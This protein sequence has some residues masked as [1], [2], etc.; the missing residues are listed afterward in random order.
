[1]PFLRSIDRRR[2]DRSRGQSLVEFALVLPIML[3]LLLAALD[4]GRVYLGWVNLQSM[5]RIAANIAANNP[6][7]WTGAGDAAVKAKYQ[8]QIRNDA[9]AT[10]CQ[11]PLVSGVRTAPEPVFAGTSLGSTVTVGMTCTFDVITPIV[12]AIV[13]K[14]V[15]VSSQAS[16]P[17]KSG[18]TA[19]G[20][21]GGGN[22]SAP[23]AAFTGNATQAPNAITG[24]A[25]FTVVFRDTSG[26][27]PTSWA[28]NFADGATS[29][30]QD[31]LGHTFEN[32]GTYVVTM[33]ATN[34][35][36]YSTQSMG[37]T[38]LASSDVSFTATPM[39]GDRPLKVDF[40][41]TST[42][43]GTA[44]TWNFG[45]GQGTATGQSATKTYNSAGT[46]TVTLT[47]T[48][49]T[50]TKSTTRTITVAPGLCTVPSL[51]GIRVNDA[52][53]EWNKANFTG[54]VTSGPGAP[55]GNYFITAQDIVALSPVPCDSNVMVN[56][57]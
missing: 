15:A 10:N 37:V 9:T 16:F 38:V 11:L 25:P 57:P 6:N 13:G 47:V 33:T 41:D 12:S 4:F 56:R 26:G 45:A 14:S 54:T 36:G 48:Y 5:T 49:P 43:G 39:T 28:W 40:T 35:N 17:V 32:A 24:T 52:Q 55:N 2:R 18:M 27:W 31:P 7:A 21:A 51:N 20:G 8:N 44:Y 19:V 22:T 1:M 53:A 34:A 29:I 3:L 30:A 23:N 46:Y 42:P 50:E